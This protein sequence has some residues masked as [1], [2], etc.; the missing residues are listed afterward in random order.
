ME[1][2]ILFRT[3][4]IGGYNKS[5]VRDYIRRL[6]FELMRSKVDKEGTENSLLEKDRGKGGPDVLVLNEV[7]ERDT[8]EKEALA[9]EY[10]AVDKQ[11]S[12]RIDELNQKLKEAEEELALKDKKLIEK[13]Q[14]LNTENRE[15]REKL[16]KLLELT[17]DN[18]QKEKR[19]EEL[20]LLN[21]NLQKEKEKLLEERKNYESDYTAVKNVLL[22]AR[23]DAEIIVSKA[24]A[25]A[26]MLLRDAQQ[27]IEDRKREACVLLIKCLEDNQYSLSVSKSRMEDQIKNIEKIHE[28]LHV[29]QE[30]VRQFQGKSD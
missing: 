30:N 2:E 4:I 23:V 1:K 11:S 10:R 7:D 6:E 15:L 26:D 12:A 29:L 21:E 27:Q 3:S 8:A 16:S 19:I 25:K 14:Q 13:E 9:D 17:P 24:K 22:N 18:G 5:D 20:S 28:E